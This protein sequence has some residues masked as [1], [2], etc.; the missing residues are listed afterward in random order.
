M[1]ARLAALLGATALALALPAAAQTPVAAPAR[2]AYAAAFFAD[3]RPGNAYEMLQRAPG[4]AFA[5]GDSDVRGFAGAGGNVLIDGERPTSKSVGLSD[6]LRRIPAAAVDRIE[7]IRAGDPSIDLQG[8]P[9]VANVVRVP[10]SG[11]SLVV[12][13]ASKRFSDGWL[14]PRFSVEASRLLGPVLLEGAF[15]IDV[16]LDEES[17]TGRRRTVTPGG[18]VLRDN[19]LFSRERGGELSANGGAT[20]RRD[21]DAWRLNVGLVR[22]AERSIDR[23]DL[24]TTTERR[25]YRSLEAGGDYERTLSDALSGKVVVLQTL[26]RDASAERST[27]SGEVETARSDETSGESILRGSLTWRPRAS[28]SLETGGEGAFNWL[29]SD[30]AVTAGGRPVPLPNDNVRIE[31]QRAEAFATGAW[32]V[33][34][35]L[36]VEGSLR[37]ETSRLI[38]S[39][40]STLI[41]TFFF[42][43]PRATLSYAPS[44]ATNLRLRFEREVSQLN[45]G[46]FAASTDLNLGV[47]NGGNARLAP[48]RAWVVEAAFERRFWG[49]GAAVVTL[50]HAW[51][52]QVVDRL[53]INGR[54]DGPGNIGDG[55]RDRAKLTVTLPL[56]RLGVSGGRIA[57]EGFIR[58]S[59][60]T[61]P[62]T[63]GKRR[64]SDEGPYGGS[65][66]VSQDLARLTST[67]GVEVDLGGTARSFRTDEVR[68]ETTQ[69][70]LIAFW[71]YKPRSDLSIKLE[72]ENV[73]GRSFNR[74]RTLY[75]GPRNLGVVEAI[76]RRGAKLDPFVTLRFRKA[77]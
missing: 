37:V 51:V 38:Q 48:E 11:G 10:G 73:T 67:W 71:D 18:V 14:G 72:I 46:D 49:A 28:L 24:Q 25:T 39:G 7:L 31:E 55:V 65:F 45:F 58:R 19:A 61:D 50:T 70:L 66:T 21:A 34:D 44:A 36:S 9:L 8:Q 15:K 62:V 1:P 77:L 33:N 52:Q 12:T 60:V 57:G 43:K 40:D 69:P 2:T 68:R 47:V 74:T 54:F 27:N 30:V 3:F 20:M 6:L 35:K 64:I 23:L 41:R 59:S 26:G 32:T 13:V 42:A 75:D 53:P 76:E 5:E 22:G 17:G 56:D 16:D 4:F 63:G 29:E